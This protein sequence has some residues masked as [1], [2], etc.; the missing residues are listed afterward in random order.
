MTLYLPRTSTAR[1]TE[2]LAAERHSIGG[3]A[4]NMVLTLVVVTDEA[5]HHEAI[6]AATEASKEHPSRIVALIRRE[7]ATEP[8]LDAEIRRPGAAGPGE[9]LLLRLYG[10]LTEHADAVLTP[11]LVPDSP[12]VVWWAGKGP[13]DPAG[14]PVGALAHRRITDAAAA[15]DPRGDLRA[16]IALY[17]P[18]DTDLTWARITPWRALL[19]S[20]MDH[21]CGWVTTGEIAAEPDQPSADLLASWLSLR[22]EIEIRRVISAGPGIS[23]A[24]LETNGGQ[25]SLE[26]IDERAATLERPG[27]PNQT[28]SLPRR[29]GAEALAEELRRL[30]A[31]VTYEHS[32]RHLEHI[33]S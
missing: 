5:G 18:G 29:R 8:M 2:V 14:D 19:A 27:Y 1:I 11:L 6:E 9:T 17:R 15:A 12:V 16:R 25:I 21:P 28:V 20:T 4:M 10:P 23:H 30:D 7:R 13:R 22:L 33:L 3:G 26:R 32:A 31:D 24:T